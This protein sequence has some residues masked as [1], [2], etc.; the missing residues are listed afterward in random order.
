MSPAPPRGETMYGSGIFSQEYFD[1][2]YLHLIVFW[3]L[4]KP[5]LLK[6]LF[7]CKDS[8]TESFEV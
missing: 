2:W 7:I 4:D 6:C 8:D 1:T 5:A 3:F